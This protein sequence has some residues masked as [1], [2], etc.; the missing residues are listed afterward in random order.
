MNYDEYL[1]EC[2][3]VFRRAFRKELTECEHSIG[4]HVNKYH[5]EGNVFTHTMMV[6]KEFVDNY[7]YNYDESLAKMGLLACLCHDLGKPFSK[8]YDE[9]RG[10][11]F[12]TG[13]E[14]ISSM[15]FLDLISDS[16]FDFDVT[17]REVE[18]ILK[19]ILGH[20][21]AHGTHVDDIYSDPDERLLLSVVN[22]CDSKGRIWS[23][24]V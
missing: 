11:T 14:L 22:E 23:D 9:K 18:I 24:N 20:T 19:A 1:K 2:L 13:H 10:R 7:Y 17:D 4:D 6:V 21:A 12:M 3:Y 5:M 15:K 16:T 8:R